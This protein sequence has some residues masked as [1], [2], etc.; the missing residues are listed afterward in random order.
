MPVCRLDSP[1]NKVNVASIVYVVWREIIAPPIYLGAWSMAV[2][3]FCLCVCTGTLV[4][5]I[6]PLDCL[7]RDCL[8][9]DGIITATC[10]V[11]D[12]H[13]VKHTSTV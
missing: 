10:L 12:N 2:A 4:L 1:L 3:A 13:N 9:R 7:Y 8:Y 6:I 5:F 11:Y